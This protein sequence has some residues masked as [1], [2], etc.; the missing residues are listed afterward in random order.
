MKIYKYITGTSMAGINYIKLPDD[1]ICYNQAINDYGQQWLVILDSKYWRENYEEIF[2]KQRDRWNVQVT[3]IGSKAYVFLFNIISYEWESITTEEYE[4]KVL[5]EVKKYYLIE[6]RRENKEWK[7]EVSADSWCGGLDVLCTEW[8]DA[9]GKT[10]IITRYETIHTPMSISK[11]V[12]LDRGIQTIKI[13]WDDPKDRLKKWD[14]SKQN[15]LP[16]DLYVPSDWQNEIKDTTD[17]SLFDEMK[18]QYI[19]FIN[20]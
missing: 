2:P 5:T 14:I 8:K 4:E 1:A 6:N 19:K 16:M 10:L 3:E 7:E 11:I 12:G 17:S 18:N 9:T 15:I 13:S 20:D